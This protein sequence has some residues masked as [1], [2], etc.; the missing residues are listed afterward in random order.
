M[1]LVCDSCTF[2]ANGWIWTPTVLQQTHLR[3]V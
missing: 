3:E 1:H 2:S